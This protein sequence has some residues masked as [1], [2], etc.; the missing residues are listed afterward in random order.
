MRPVVL[1]GCG[2]CPDLTSE[3]ADISVSTAE[4]RSGCN[5][6]LVRSPRGQELLE[7]ASRQGLLEIEPMPQESMEHLR[8]AA[9][10]KRAQAQAA[11]K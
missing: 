2:Q 10:N 1:K 8:A 6:I 5:T 4:G 11:W 9:A 7:L 3:L